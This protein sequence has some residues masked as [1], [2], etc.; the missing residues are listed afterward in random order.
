MTLF[1]KYFSV[2]VAVVAV[3]TIMGGL[4]IISQLLCCAPILQ[5]KTNDEHGDGEELE[6]G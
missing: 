4:N 2:I 6:N 5:K 3:V 1:Y